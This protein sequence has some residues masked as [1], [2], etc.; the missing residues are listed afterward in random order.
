V[1]SGSDGIKPRIRASVVLPPLDQA[2]IRSS[3]EDDSV[4]IGA[5]LVSNAAVSTRTASLTSTVVGQKKSLGCE[6]TSRMVDDGY[7]L[8]YGS[9]YFAIGPSG[10]SIHVARRMTFGAVPVVAVVVGR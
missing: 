2:W 9:V 10:A 8:R 4:L 5:E 1:Y 6:R 7:S 3:G